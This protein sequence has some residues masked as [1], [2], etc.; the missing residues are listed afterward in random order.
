MKP[1]VGKDLQM[2]LLQ[3][4]AIF[5]HAIKYQ[6]VPIS[7]PKSNRFPNLLACPEL[8]FQAVSSDVQ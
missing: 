4:I 7:S 8:R 6:H 3:V 1:S 5:F 2:P